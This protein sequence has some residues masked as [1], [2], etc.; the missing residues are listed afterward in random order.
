MVG[1]VPH[2]SEYSCDGRLVM[3]GVEGDVAINV[4]GLPI[5]ACAKSGITP[6]HKDIEE[7]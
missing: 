3:V 7:Y 4:G 5:H 2:T 1:S 6:G